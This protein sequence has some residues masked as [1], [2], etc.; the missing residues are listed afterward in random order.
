MATLNFKFVANDAG[1]KSGVAAAKGHLDDLDGK[2]T[3]IGANIG[4]AFAAM[5]AAL[6]AAG[7]VRGLKDAAQAA[8][9]D[10]IAQRLLAEQL[11]L[12]TGA[13]DE[14]VAAAERFISKMSLMSGIADDNLRPALQNAVRGTGSLAE[15]Q[16]VLAIAMDGAAASGKPLDTVLQALIKAHN[17]NETAL[18]KLAPQLKASK[19]D[20]DDYAA[21]V[22]GMAEISANPFD[23]FKVSV[24]EAKEVIGAALLPALNT[25]IDTLSPLV[26]SLAPTL[27]KVVAALAPIF[28]ALAPVI[29][30]VVNSLLPLI[31]VLLKLIEALLPIITELLPPL[32]DL[33][34]ALIPV[35][36]PIIDIL[37]AVLIPI[38]KIVVD[39]LVL[40]V[41]HIKNVV[42]AFPSVGKAIQTVFGNIGNF[43][44][45]L[46]NGWIN[47][48]EG[49][50]NG[51]ISGVN[52]IIDGLNLL[53]KYGPIKFAI[54]RIP[55][56]NIPNLA[57]GGIIPATPG[58][59]LVNVAEAGKAEAVIPLD[60][61]GDLSGKGN[62]VNVY[63]NQAVTA[64][65]I[66]DTL[67]RYARSNG[68]SIASVLV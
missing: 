24:D 60:R 33:L 34:M 66:I 2:T 31:P 15:G 4:K 45:T 56:L 9:E 57:D 59:R 30:K 39:V 42:D 19:G 55:A 43:F 25:L 3:S 20:I 22:K 21:S 6:L 40:W 50:V 11:K 10:E 1:L 51:V 65:T 46:I 8:Q 23:K 48:F 29:V 7:L 26:T 41:K 27:A 37:V 49:F 61:L 64:Q 58:G 32:V 67:N 36:T 5:G 18:Y 62:T 52:G 13:T 35:I 16:K 28:T 68:T 12:T 47:L 38:L 14:Q 54:G 17:G 63:I 44:K 53:G